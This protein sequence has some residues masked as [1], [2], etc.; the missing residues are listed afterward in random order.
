MNLP[1]AV[2]FILFLTAVVF[3]LKY[4]KVHG[5]ED[6]TGSCGSCNGHCAANLKK[7]LQKARIEL[8]NEKKQKCC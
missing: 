6:C 1:T 3:A 7:G 4:V 5:T 8:E 2:I